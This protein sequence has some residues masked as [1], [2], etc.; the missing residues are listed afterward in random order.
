M[1]SS[2]S[3]AR[4][5]SFI[6]NLG[7]LI[8]SRPPPL[9]LKSARLNSPSLGALEREK[10]PDPTLASVIDRYSDESVKDI[11]RTKTQV[12]RAIKRGCGNSCSHLRGKA[13]ILAAERPLQIA[14]RRF[15]SAQLRMPLSSA[16]KAM[17]SCAS[18]R[19]AYS[20][21]FRHSLATPAYTH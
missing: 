4:A 20:G 8:G 6:A 5:Q 2:S 16:S 17:P 3:S 11:G 13:S 1:R 10:A 19:L 18:W 21:P 9:G 7:R 14:C 12:L 15:G